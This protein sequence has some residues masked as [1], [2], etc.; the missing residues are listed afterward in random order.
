MGVNPSGLGAVKAP[1]P[2]FLSTFFFFVKFL[3]LTINIF[4]FLQYVFGFNPNLPLPSLQRLLKSMDI[5]CIWTVN[6]VKCEINLRAT[7]AAS[8]LTPQGTRGI[9]KYMLYYVHI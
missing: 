4:I 2:N 1:L 6:R 3:F 7:K 8:K 9:S 5:N